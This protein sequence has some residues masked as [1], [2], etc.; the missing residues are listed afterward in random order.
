MSEILTEVPAKRHVENEAIRTAVEEFLPWRGRIF[1][2]CP[3]ELAYRF[4]V[5][6]LN[7]AYTKATGMDIGEYT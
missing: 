5:V 2:H 7:N 1:M 3:H 6:K 4:P